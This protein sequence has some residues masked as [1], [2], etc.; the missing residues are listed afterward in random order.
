MSVPGHADVIILSR[1]PGTSLSPGDLV[2][3]RRPLRPP[4][5][6]R[7]WSATSWRASIRTSCGVS[8]A[9]PAYLAPL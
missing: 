9:S 2:P 3:E 1:R 7:S 6:A 4:G 5:L 8:I